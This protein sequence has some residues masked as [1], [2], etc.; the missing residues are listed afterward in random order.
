M[1]FELLDGFCTLDISLIEGP[2]EELCVR[3]T[4]LLLTLILDLL[5]RQEVSLVRGYDSPRRGNF[6]RALCEWVIINLAHHIESNPKTCYKGS[7]QLLKLL[8]FIPAHD[9]QELIEIDLS[10]LIHIN[11]IH[12]VLLVLLQSGGG[13][14]NAQRGNGSENFSALSWPFFQIGKLPLKISENIR[15]NF[16]KPLQLSANFYILREYSRAITALCATWLP[17]LCHDS[18]QWCRG[19]H[20]NEVLH[21]QWLCIATS[22][23]TILIFWGTTTYRTITPPHPHRIALLQPRGCGWGYRSSS[24]ILFNFFPGFLGFPC[25]IPYMGHF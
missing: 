6:K 15:E 8:L 5:Y 21:L 25:L 10:T 7:L 18:P 11:S 14:P 12:E 23:I 2:F 13:V 17:Y 4:K 20:T 16:C 3:S 19:S 22:P 9:L 1:I 24:C